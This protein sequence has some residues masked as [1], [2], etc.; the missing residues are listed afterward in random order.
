VPSPD[1]AF[2]TPARLCAS[3]AL[4]VSLM[5]VVGA[6]APALR[7][8]LG[9]S[10]SALTVAFVFGMLGAVA[11]STLAGGAGHRLLELT[12]LAL[13]TAATMALATTV[14]SL[15]ALTVLMLCAGTAAFALNASSQAETMRRAGDARARALSQFHVWGGAGGAGFPLLVAGMLAIG[16][17]WQ[18]AFALL[19]AGYLVYALVNRDLRMVR[20]PRPAGAGRPALSAR[21]RWAVAGAVLGG[22]LQITFP[23][24]LASL[25]VDSYAAGPALGSAGV[26]VYAAGVLVARAG[27][28]R[29]LPRLGVARELQLSCV[30]LVAGYAGVLVAPTV[31]VV[32]AAAFCLGLG[33]GQLM[34]LGMARSAREI[35]DDRY[36]TGVVF[37]LNSAMQIV[38]PGVVAL[39]ALALEL[40]VAIL[41]TFPLVV[42]IACAEWR[43]RAN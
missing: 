3:S 35:A 20:T 39:L 36:A 16:L 2:R 13:A 34:P 14:Q 32:F 38:V 31:A 24:Y 15:P 19:A 27:G 42:L 1:P 37:A 8:H 25:L 40:R 6:T 10:T 9:V 30:A 33:T 18:A 41:L 28:T 11:G 4:T 26:S 12:P 43:S 21:A 29:V 5:S 22:G 23:L 17:P 7:S